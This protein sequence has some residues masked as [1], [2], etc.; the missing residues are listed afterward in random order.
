MVDFTCDLSKVVL[1]YMFLFLIDKTRNNLFEF[2]VV[3][4]R[5]LLYQ[6]QPFLYRSVFCALSKRLPLNPYL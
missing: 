5:W 2:S 6:K 4:K 1:V 3:N